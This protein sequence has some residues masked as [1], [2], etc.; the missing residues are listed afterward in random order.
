MQTLVYLLPMACCTHFPV[1]GDLSE[2]NLLLL[3]KQLFVIDVGQ[4]VDTRHP[5][6]E[7]LLRRDVDNVFRFLVRSFGFSD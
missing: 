6:A 1:H 3:N 7:D 4:A 5:A 2:Y